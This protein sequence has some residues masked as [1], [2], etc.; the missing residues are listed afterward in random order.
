MNMLKT[1][2][3][4]TFMTL[5]LVFV[6]GAIGGRSGM[7]MAFGLA[8]V[9]N[10]VSYW[11]SDKI[12]LSMYGAQPVTESQAPELH[13]MVRRLSQKAGLPMPKVY[14]IPEQALNA[15]AT[16]RNPEHG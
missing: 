10:F 7:I 1:V 13:A 14:I 8:L 6:G 9:M 12:V 11:F 5:L 16:G 2:V 4:L 15:F 3:L